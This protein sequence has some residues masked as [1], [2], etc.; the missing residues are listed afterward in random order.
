M[1]ANEPVYLPVFLIQLLAFRYHVVF[2]G[3]AFVKMHINV[4]TLV[5]YTE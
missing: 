4:L 5:L 1:F 2:P 3:K